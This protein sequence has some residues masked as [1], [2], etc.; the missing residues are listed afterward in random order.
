MNKRGTKRKHW[1]HFNYFKQASRWPCRYHFEIVRV[2]GIVRML[3]MMW[4]KLLSMSKKCL[5]QNEGSAMTVTPAWLSFQAL[6]LTSPATWHT[7]ELLDAS[8]RFHLIGLV[9]CSAHLRTGP[10][11]KLNTDT[12]WETEQR[13]FPLNHIIY[14]PEEVPIYVYSQRSRFLVRMTT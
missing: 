6:W 8:G 3:L 1:R 13:V 14:Q 12:E 5:W 9:C 2:D 4:T 11:S 7:N 10:S